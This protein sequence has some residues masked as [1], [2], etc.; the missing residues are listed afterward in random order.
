MLSLLK[1]FCL[2]LHRIAARR[3]GSRSTRENL[4]WAA[5][6][7]TLTLSPAG[8]SQNVGDANEGG[9]LTPMGGAQFQFTWWARPGV[10][11]LVEV[12]NDLVNWH[13]V[14]T[15]FLGAGGFAPPVYLLGTGDSMFVRLNTDPFH[16]DAD[17]DGISDAWEIL[18]GLDSRVND[19]AGDP[20]AD[21]LTN[22]EE[23]GLG[24][25]PK[26]AADTGA[27]AAAAVGLVVHT[28]VD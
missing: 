11:Y 2:R 27:A 24:T 13:Y 10:Y 22:L 28:D 20:D 21:Q 18:H 25:D 23:Y 12:S 16:S 17:G 8:H 1:S 14:E 4:L 15:L 26:R 19:A 3:T 9:T 5:A 7:I 6:F